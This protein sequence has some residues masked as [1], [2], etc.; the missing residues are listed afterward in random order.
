MILFQSGVMSDAKT[1]EKNT[2]YLPTNYLKCTEESRMTIYIFKSHNT[3]FEALPHVNEFYELV[4]AGFFL[5][6]YAMM[7]TW[8]HIMNN[9]QVVGI[10]KVDTSSNNS[11]QR[12]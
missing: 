11:H 1:R 10:Y 12:L 7:Q 6:I 3:F 2:N 9:K 5:P 4:S 8:F